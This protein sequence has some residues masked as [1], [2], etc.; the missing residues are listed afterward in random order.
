MGAAEKPLTIARLPGCSKGCVE[1]LLAPAP[2]RRGSSRAAGHS[3]FL[4]AAGAV[5]PG[6]EEDE[7]SPGTMTVSAGGVGRGRGGRTMGVEDVKGEV[8]DS[9]PWAEA[10][11][12]FEPAAVRCARR[13]SNRVDN[14]YAP[15]KNTS[16]GAGAG[17]ASGGGRSGARTTT[18]TMDRKRREARRRKKRQQQQQ[19]QQ[20]YK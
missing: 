3:H 18:P 14:R 17:A 9:G 20:Q 1:V 15:P 11:I 2:S 16:V 4:G 13:R 5:L 8:D 7:G 12:N 10:E 19:Q 6:D